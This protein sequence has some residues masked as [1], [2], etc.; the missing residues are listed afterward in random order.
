MKPFRDWLVFSKIMTIC[1]LTVFTI[2]IGILFYF[3]PL[4]EDSLMTEKRLATKHLIEV[5][6]GVI[7]SYH[8]QAVAGGI[9]EE[10]A[11]K[12]ALAA[13]RM[14]RYEN[15]QYFWINDTRPVMIMHPFS[16]DLEGEEVSD[17]QDPTGK[18]IFIE[19]ANVAKTSGEGYVD[20]MWP[21]PGMVKPV[22]KVSYVKCYRDWDWVVG[23]GIYVDDVKD[24]VNILRIKILAVTFIG[25]IFILLLSYYISRRITN[26]L[27]KAVAISNQLAQG[28]LKVEIGRITADETGQLLQSMGQMIMYIQE[29]ASV[30]KE[31]AR[32][33]ISIRVKPESGR[34][35][36]NHSF[37]E[38][39][40]YINNVATRAEQIAEGNLTVDITP[41][42]E[43][44]ILNNSFRNMV[45]HLRRMVEDLIE[46]ANQIGATVDKLNINSKLISEGAVQQSAASDQTTASMEQMASSIREIAS[47]SES[48]NKNMGD[49]SQ[50]IQQ[51]TESI[52]SIAENATELASSVE[53]TSATIE[54]MAVSIEQVAHNALQVSKS[55]DSAVKEAQDGSRAVK[56]TIDGMQG[57][58]TTMKKIVTM[59]EKLNDNSKQ[60]NNI[61]YV[62]DEIAE[63]TNL[64]ALN[65]AIEAARAG[66]HGRGFAVVADEVRKLAERSASSARE[67]VQL[68]A[69]VQ[70]DTEDTIRATERG[71]QEVND[72]V[73]LAMQ[74]GDALEKILSTINA[75]SRMTLEVSKVTDQQSKASEQ[76][77][78]A[79]ENM[80]RMTQNVHTATKDQ[81]MG[82]E[83]IMSATQMVNNMTKQVFLATNE[84]RRGG[85]Q[86]VQAV[87][88]I[89]QISQQNIKIA[90]QIVDVTQTLSKQAEKLREIT[91][92]FQV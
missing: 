67:I 79:V 27:H 22:P 15:D 82:S 39:I 31:V 49:T 86:I 66:E 88:N 35:V 53:E 87:E 54:E 63:Q 17:F 76:V 56:K 45:I 48:V 46:S 33:N 64:L 12:N 1:I 52:Q 83:Q 57:I 84:Q 3:L 11:Q 81:A 60:I 4:V 92:Q 78:K 65:A 90:N 10:T 20:Y 25:S 71:S 85:E 91:N 23:S 75:I 77:V 41:K 24:Q 72:G 50:S 34:D 26:P 37:A 74:A 42:S 19:F 18:R 7:K 14:L 40:Q 44:D 73:S 29:V 47:N 21:K 28:D 5:A 2:L 16:T 6:H 51:M 38:T 55:S 89:S 30:A 68:I 62:I 32:G 61:V 43:Q 69:G 9:P 8:E 80:R 13:V 58:F 59:I 70:K 36:L